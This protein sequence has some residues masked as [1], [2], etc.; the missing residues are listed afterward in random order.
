MLGC[1]II[2]AWTLILGPQL[3][4][5]AKGDWL[6]ARATYFDAP[7]YWK[8]NFRPGV[9]G[10]LYGNS[11]QYQNRKEGVAQSNADFPLQFDAVGAVTNLMETHIG[12]AAQVP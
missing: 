12:K 6:P 1:I 10:D 2:L 7:D 11:C 3:S 9:F 5:A 8:E 4:S